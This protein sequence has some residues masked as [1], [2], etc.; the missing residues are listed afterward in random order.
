MD[1]PLAASTA[2]LVP[3]DSPKSGPD[4]SAFQ[5]G[6]VVA[7][8]ENGAG[9]DYVVVSG[10]PSERNWGLSSSIVSV[11]ST[12]GGG[13]GG[14]GAGS[15]GSSNSIATGKAFLGKGKIDPRAQDE[16]IAFMLGKK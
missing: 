16:F 14:G 6:F 8:A 7:G 13:G 9:D 12:V 4:G 11:G 3:G 2:T 10:T 1:S 5:A 15:S